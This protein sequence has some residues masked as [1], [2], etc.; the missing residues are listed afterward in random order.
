MYYVTYLHRPTKWIDI[1]RQKN[2]LSEKEQGWEMEATEKEVKR[3]KAELQGVEAQ[4][5]TR[6]KELTVERLTVERPTLAAWLSPIFTILS[7]RST[8]TDT[9]RP[10]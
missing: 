9:G 10:P 7:F 5:E 8:V 1:E 3:I 6:L 4:K 2:K